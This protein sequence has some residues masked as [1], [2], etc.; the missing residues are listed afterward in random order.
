MKRIE[1]LLTWVKDLISANISA[2]LTAITAE[3][4]DGISLPVPLGY[5][6]YELGAIDQM[7]Y[8]QVLPDVTETVIPGDTWDQDENRIII[9][10]HNVAYEG[11]IEYCAKRTYRYERAISELILSDRTL[12]D[13]VT[14]FYKTLSDFKEMYTDENGFKQEVW[15]HCTIKMHE[16]A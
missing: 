8:V 16:T 15:I 5:S 9:I 12:T 10:A 14:A 3:M 13:R 11:S 6:I 2:K 1:Y 7:P 4:A